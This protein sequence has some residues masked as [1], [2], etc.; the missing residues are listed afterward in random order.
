MVR[1]AD[2]TIYFLAAFR[3]NARGVSGEVIITVL[4]FVPVSI[5]PV[6]DNPAHQDLSGIDGEE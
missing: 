3:A 1:T 6:G 2:P 5:S 4:A